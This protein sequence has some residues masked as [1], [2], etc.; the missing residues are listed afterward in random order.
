VE[1]LEE[2]QELAKPPLPEEPPVTPAEDQFVAPPPALPEPAEI[3]EGD[4]AVGEI[5][6]PAMGFDIIGGG[7][8][9]FDG[10]SET[11]STASLML[12]TQWRGGDEGLKLLKDVPEIWSISVSGAK[13]TDESL[14]YFAELPHLANLQVRDASFTRQ[15]LQKL[16]KQKPELQIQARGEAMLGVNADVGISPLTLTSVFQDAG[17]YQAGLRE[18]DV[19]LSVD[20]VSIMEFSD[21]T[22]S[23]YGRKAGEKIRLAYEREGVKKTVEVTLK[24]RRD[25]Q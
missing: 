15:G 8:V 18:G 17:A 12:G 6:L 22:I 14:Q 24:K 23:I 25:D 10:E 1:T 3:L 7:I 20:G 13:I 16:R 2:F 11:D 5:G 9:D 21:L 19:I 4:I